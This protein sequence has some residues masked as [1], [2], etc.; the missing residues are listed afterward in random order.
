VLT[1]GLEKILRIC[2]LDHERYD[3]LWECHNGVAGGHVGGKATIIKVLQAWLWW[4]T[5][6]KDTKAHDVC[7]R[8]GKPYQRDEL[9]LHPIKDLQALKKWDIDFIR[10]INP[11]A[12]HSK[13]RYIITTTYYLMRWD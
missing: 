9:P 12:R 6:F 11:P 2:V 4:T 3:I 8:V 5:M 13:V 1:L 7:Q 10:P